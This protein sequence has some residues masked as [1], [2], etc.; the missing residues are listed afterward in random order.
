MHNY[1]CPKNGVQVNYITEIGRGLR[2][3]I[4]SVLSA[5]YCKRKGLDT[6]AYDSIPF[7]SPSWSI[8]YNLSY[9]EDIW[10]DLPEFYDCLVDYLGQGDCL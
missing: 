3:P 6:Y 7:L 4:Q 1:L 5:H 10:L 2:S 9:G 8:N